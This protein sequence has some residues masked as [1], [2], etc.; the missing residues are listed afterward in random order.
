[1]RNGLVGSILALAP[2][3]TLSS[4]T[5]A[6][7]APQSGGSKTQAV[8]SPAARDLSGVWLMDVNAYHNNPSSGS[9]KAAPMTAW[10]QERYKASAGK[11]GYDDPTYH[12]DPPGLPRVALGQAPFEIIQI[13]GRI[14]VLYE[15]FYA[16]RTI[17]MDGR[18][19]P[20][21]PDP[22]WYGYSV[23]RWEGDTLV[24]DTVGFNDRSWLDGGGHPHSDA[25]QVVERYRRVDRDT[26]ELNMT[27]NDSKAYTKPW[28]SSAPKSYKLA[29][30]VG[31]KAE[32]LELPCVPE[33]EESFRKVVREPAAA[34]PSK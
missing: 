8:A 17:W 25:M 24:V 14:L 21:D 23:G 11:P 13:P 10:A 16:R 29:P 18:T 19:V 4:I 33:D 5:L 7:G 32:V 22:T 3:L 27:I 12:C 20:K 1:M 9:L 6:H 30:K 34:K 31:P 2:V 28:V 15:D 26:L